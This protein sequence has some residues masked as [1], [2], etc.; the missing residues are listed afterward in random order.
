MM[1][2]EVFRVI[3]NKVEAKW[4]KILTVFGQKQMEQKPLG[5]FVKISNFLKV[6]VS[7]KTS[8]EMMFGEV[9]RVIGNK[10]EA[11]LTVFGQKP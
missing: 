5:N 9:F 10:V 7:G 3:G 8:L 6:S 2:G 4:F 1:F 11:K